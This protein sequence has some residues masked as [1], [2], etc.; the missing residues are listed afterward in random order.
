MVVCFPVVEEL[1]VQVKQVTFSVKSS[2]VSNPCSSIANSQTSQEAMA[3][4]CHP[5]P[6]VVGLVLPACYGPC[7]VAGLVLL[8][9]TI[10]LVP[11]CVHLRSRYL[12]A[13]F[14][15]PNIRTYID[16]THALEYC[17]WSMVSHIDFINRNQ[18]HR[19]SLIHQQVGS[20]G[21]YVPHPAAIYCHV[22]STNP[23]IP[24]CRPNV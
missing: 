17:Y 20:V 16:C 10:A 14:E 21:Y 18:W 6:Y 15:L 13:G 19:S 3:T 4:F 8:F 7:W 22:T 23:N 12:E 5:S 2:T 11:A 24:R 1:P 9:Y